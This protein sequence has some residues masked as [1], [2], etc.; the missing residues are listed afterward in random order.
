MS[1]ESD[2]DNNFRDRLTPEQQELQAEQESGENE[3]IRYNYEISTYGVDFTV[4]ILVRKLQK[5]EFI[6]P[7]YQR[8]YVW[9]KAE[10]SRFIESLLMDLPIPTIFL[11]KTNDE[12]FMVIDGQQRLKTIE[13]FFANQFPTGTKP[14]TSFALQL[15]KSNPLHGKTYQD[16]ADVYQRK[17]DN[18]MLHITVVKQEKP[19]RSQSGIYLVF[20]RLNSS[21][22]VLAPQELRACM[23]MGEFNNQLE[24]LNQNQHWRAI[25]GKEDNRKKDEEYILRF[26][27][28]YYNRA[29][30]KAPY[31]KFMNEFMSAHKDGSNIDFQLFGRTIKL[32]Y[33][34]FNGEPNKAFRPFKIFNAACFDSVMVA[35]AHKLSSNTELKPQRVKTLY[36]EL[37]QNN[38]YKE[39]CKGPTADENHVDKRFDLAQ[40]TFAKL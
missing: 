14:A 8:N 28:Y 10:A 26:Y 13:G 35:L 21:G 15:G 12:K 17:L 29:N 39:Y 9:N 32:V 25:Y 40:Q 36:D 6:I 2:I 33:D 27:A 24:Q 30:Y 11:A 18:A 22:R 34:A 37:L 4:E 38:T 7:N 3:D 1:Q 16:L 19:D 20:E 23:Y 5:Q 31:K